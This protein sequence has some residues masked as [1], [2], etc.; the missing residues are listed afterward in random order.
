MTLCS[1]DGMNVDMYKESA[2]SQYVYVDA[3]INRGWGGGGGVA[4]NSL[5]AGYKGNTVAGSGKMRLGEHS[6]SESS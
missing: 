6:Y 2:S 4:C 3:I 5:F 1:R